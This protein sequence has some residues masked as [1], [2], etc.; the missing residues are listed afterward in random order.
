MKG[1]EPVI[2]VLNARLKEELAAVNQYTVHAEMY[3]NW[4]FTKLAE[5][6]NK[7]AS[8]EREHSKELIERILFLEGLPVANVLAP[9]KVGKLPE[10]MIANDLA[11][12]LEAIKKYNDSVE[13]ACTNKDEGTADLFRHILKEEEAH[14]NYLEALV[15]QIKMVGCQNFLAVYI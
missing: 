11:S 3:S 14:A 6:A 15:A 1:K 9:V 10:D 7:T 4:G 5:L 12:E 13:L 2:A 8:D